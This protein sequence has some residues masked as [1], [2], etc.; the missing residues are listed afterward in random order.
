M[1]DFYKFK[2]EDKKQTQLLKYNFQKIEN[3]TQLT[4]IQKETSRKN[5]PMFFDGKFTRSRNSFM[6]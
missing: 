2:E 6:Y 5:Y 1:L 4:K 3:F